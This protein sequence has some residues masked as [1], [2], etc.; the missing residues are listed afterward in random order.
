M[1]PSPP[2]SPT[3]QQ[4][5]AGFSGLG[6]GIA[7]A[8][9]P[10]NSTTT[11]SGTTSTNAQ[12]N[13]NSAPVFDP[14]TDALRQQIIKSLMGNLNE[15]VDLKGYE[16]QGLQT[17]NQGSEAAKTA[18]QQTLA[19][20]GLTYSPMAGAAT[21]NLETQ[22]IGQGVNFQN[23]LP[24]L[25]QQLYQQK[26]QQALQGFSAMPYGQSGQQSQSGS[27]NTNTNSNTVTKQPGSGLLSGIFG[28]LGQLASALIP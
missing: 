22:R 23:Q 18:L 4:Y 19:S 10:G 11:S 9:S 6:Q 12:G 17:I 13:F 20:R 28:G 14:Q 21:A 8:T 7:S 27:Q 24:L 3:W 5:L 26:L 1:T 2:T 15:D 16:S 25:K